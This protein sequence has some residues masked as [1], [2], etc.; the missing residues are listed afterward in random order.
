[1]PIWIRPQFS[2]KTETSL[3][4]PQIL[5]S[6]W[7]AVCLAVA[8]ISGTIAPVLHAETPYPIESFA[9][10]AELTQEA[11]IQTKR[12]DK[13]LSTDAS[14]EKDKEK[15]VAQAFGLIAC[16]GQ[17]LAEH[18]EWEKAT[19]NGPALR[20]AA[21]T[22][23]SDEDRDAALAA[24]G[25]VKDVIAGKVEG[26]HERLHPWN[27][28]IGMYALM[29]EINTRNS[30]YLKIF[31]RPRGTPEEASPV[32]AWG[33]LGAA[34]KADNYGAGDEEDEK[35]WNTWSDEFYETAVK[36]GKA[37]REKD[38]VESRK[39]FDKANAGCK[40]CHEKFK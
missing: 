5:R 4:M 30:E 16:V 31:R 35:L 25:K 13:L 6:K 23:S 29:E 40:V 27:E 26:E 10:L 20:D 33:L 18:K 11:T 2:L 21:L 1:M 38:K 15:H 28:L 17:G 34:M 9:S 32:V 37:I 12:L 36:L 7:T 3:A 19:I 22:Y 24:L 39:W 14:F 8:T